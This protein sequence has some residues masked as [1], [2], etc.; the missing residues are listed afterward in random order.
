M[1]SIIENGVV[2]AMLIRCDEMRGELG[3]YCI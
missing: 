2:I 3:Y 1:D